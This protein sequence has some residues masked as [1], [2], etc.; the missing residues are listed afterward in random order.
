[1]TQVRKKLEDYWLFPY[2]AWTISIGFTIFVVFLAL[3]LRET[4]ASIEQS[5]LNLEKRMQAVEDMFAN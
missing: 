5:S 2:I 3:E 1:M 4:A